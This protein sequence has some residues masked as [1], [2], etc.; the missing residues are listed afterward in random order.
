MDQDTKLA[1]L[2][3]QAEGNADVLERTL[4][5]I[6]DLGDLPIA[7]SRDA[8]VDELGFDANP[9]T[10]IALPMSALRA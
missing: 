3:K 5:T 9:V 2:L 1:E 7:F 6:R 10:S 8:L 4:Q